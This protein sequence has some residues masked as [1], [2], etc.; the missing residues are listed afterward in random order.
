MLMAVVRHRYQ[1]TFS[2]L[3]VTS[4]TANVRVSTR[5]DVEIGVG[6]DKNYLENLVPFSAG[7]VYEENPTISYTPVQSEEYLREI[8]SPMPLDLLILISRSMTWVGLP[9][10]I[11]VSRVN[12]IRNPDFLTPPV[13]EPDP[14]FARFVELITELV[15]IVS[16]SGNQFEAG[17]RHSS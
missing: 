4:V 15:C 11:L 12:D 17:I 7:T 10:T 3:A 6:P 13:V 5:A 2:M 16:E 1:E 9:F 8:L 14:R